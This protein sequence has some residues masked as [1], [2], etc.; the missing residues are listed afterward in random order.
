MGYLCLLGCLDAGRSPDPWR[1]P[2]LGVVHLRYEWTLLALKI[3]R[4]L[5]EGRRSEALRTLTMEEV[6]VYILAR[7]L[8]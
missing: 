3:R 8:R 5:S 7:V 6:C 2:K 1:A 4:N